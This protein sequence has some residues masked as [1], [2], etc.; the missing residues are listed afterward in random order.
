MQPLKNVKIC[1]IIDDIENVNILN[2][3]II[4]YSSYKITYFEKRK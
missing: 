3:E 1:N 2:L 4:Q